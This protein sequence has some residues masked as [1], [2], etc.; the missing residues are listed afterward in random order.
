MPTY[1]EKCPSFAD[2]VAPPAE[3]NAAGE[4]A[5]STASVTSIK[6]KEFLDAADGVVGVFVLLNST[7]LGLVQNDL[8]GNIKKLRE[9]CENFPNTSST[10][11][12]IVKDEAKEAEGKSD[13]ERK[14]IKK[15]TESLLW[16]TRGLSFTCKGLSNARKDKNQS[17]SAS[18]QAAYTETLEVYHGFL[19]K[20]AI[21]LALKACPTRETLI[22]KLG[23]VEATEAA[24]VEGEVSK[25][26]EIWLA[27][28]ETI[29]KHIQAFFLAGKYDADFA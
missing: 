28:L 3:V 10:L 15:A 8:Q 24:S 23:G 6:T 4:A 12:E 26:L 7:A 5:D 17:L 14:K 20:K 21:G 13:K 1:F 2:A 19:V 9:R 29:V 11:E 16:L 27:A 25:D 18:F 22:A